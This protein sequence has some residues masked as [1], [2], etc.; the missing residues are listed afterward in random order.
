[1]VVSDWPGSRRVRSFPVWK[2]FGGHVMGSVPSPTRRRGGLRVSYGTRS[3]KPRS[4]AAEK[5]HSAGGEK[6]R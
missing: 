4:T 6:P 3:S 5:A 1:M 2:A